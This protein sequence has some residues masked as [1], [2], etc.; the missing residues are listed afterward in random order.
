MAGAKRRGVSRRDLLGSLFR[1]DKKL[2]E[3]DLEEANLSVH[4][5]DRVQE[6]LKRLQEKSSAPPHTLPRQK[7]EEK[8]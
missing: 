2:N 6:L 3:P 7:P 8:D 4:S 1:P 5:Q